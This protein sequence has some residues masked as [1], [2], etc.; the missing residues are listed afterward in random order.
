[1]DTATHG[2]NHGVLPYDLLLDVLYRLENR[3]LT[4][5]RRVCRAW[6]AAID[7]NTVLLARFHR[8]FP[9]R[10][11]PGVFLSNKFFAPA[12]SPFRKRGE[13]HT[14]RY[15]KGVFLAFDP[16]MSRHHEVFLFPQTMAQLR[17]AQPRVKVERPWEEI[18][19]EQLQYFNNFSKEDPPYEEEE[20]QQ[21]CEVEQ[22]P[23]EV[24]E[25]QDESRTSP[26]TKDPGMQEESFQNELRISSQGQYQ[27]E[28]LLHN[29]LTGVTLPGGIPIP[30]SPV[31]MGTG[32]G[33]LQPHGEH[34][35]M[36]RT[37]GDTTAAGVYPAAADTHRT[38]HNEV[39]LP[40]LLPK[41]RLQEGYDAK[42]VAAAQQHWGFHPGGQVGRGG[43]ASYEKGIHYVAIK[44]MFQLQSMVQWKHHRLQWKVFERTKGKVSLFEPLS[45][46][47]QSILDQ[48]LG[49]SDSDTDDNNNN[50]EEDEDKSDNDSDYSWNSD[51]DNFM[52]VDEDTTSMGQIH[53]TCYKIIGLH[54]YKDV[55]LHPIG[56]A[57]AYHLSTSRMQYLG[58]TP[59]VGTSG[60]PYRPCY[61][62]ALPSM[63]MPRIGIRLP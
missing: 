43:E 26:K 23:T 1:M 18:S 3:E 53:Y 30:S 32:V 37:R 35:N 40:S 6:R 52:D 49:P 46:T 36:A 62:H 33:S 13:E 7:D 59:G 2:D 61:M 16:A 12:E 29:R 41:Q 8:I 50:K 42:G 56:I 24:D 55:L 27:I 15:M 48:I 10:A 17:P 19:L 4:V 63:K 38:H 28:E 9:P 25:P 39:Q 5:S 57:V 14:F 58:Q 31:A 22:E 20:Q 34:S 44:N 51:E 21:K 54:P 60:F 47:E 11:F 45:P